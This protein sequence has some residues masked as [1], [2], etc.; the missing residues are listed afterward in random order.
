MRIGFWDLETAPH[1]ANVWGLFDQNIS[2]AQLREASEVICF[3]WMWEGDSRAK[4]WSVHKHG[5]E[6]MLQKAWDLMHEADAV[7]SWNGQ[8]FDTKTMAKEFLLAGMPPPSPT[9]EI[10]LMRAAKKR[11]RLASNKLDYVS[12]ALGLEGKVKHE[13]F[14][15]WLACMQG[16]DAAWRRMSNYCR[17]DVELLVPLFERLK[18]WIPGIASHAAFRGEDVCPACGSEDLR[19]QGRAFL[20]A[21]T[22]QRYV[23]GQ[24]RKWSRG[25]RRLE[26]TSIVEVSA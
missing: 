10:D 2:L 17:K 25:S 12:Q 5:K 21:G 14:E 19:P 26:S 18:P 9:K 22:Y 3:G 23:C 15:L 11:F 20:R 13:G 6:A 16:D 24:C 7:V 8:S 4:V 1:L